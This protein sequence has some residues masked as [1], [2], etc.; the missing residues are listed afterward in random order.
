M[1]AKAS[2]F[3]CSEELLGIRHESRRLLE[4]IAAIG[5]LPQLALIGH[6]AVDALDRQKS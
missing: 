3:Q 6:D 4:R 5:L 2:A 1:L